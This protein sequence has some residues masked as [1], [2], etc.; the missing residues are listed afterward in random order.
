MSVSSSNDAERAGVACQISEVGYSV[1]RS[2]GQKPPIFWITPDP[3]QSKVVFGLGEEHPVY[4]L[5]GPKHRADQPPMTLLD[6][7]H[8]YAATIRRL[9]PSGPC[10]LVGYCVAATA[11]REVAG[12]LE[13]EGREVDRVVMIDPPDPAETRGGWPL[14]PLW[15]RLRFALN[16]ARFHVGRLVQ[17]GVREQV[18]YL[19][20]SLQELSRRFTYARTRRVHED[21]RRSGANLPAAL[22]DNYFASVAAFQNSAPAP[23]SVPVTLI[24]P[25]D[26]PRG[27]FEYANRRWASL[28]NGAWR[29]AEVPGDSRS[30]W[31]GDGASSLCTL[32]G[33]DGSP[34]HGQVRG[35][36]DAAALASAIGAAG[37]RSR[38]E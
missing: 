38:L 30:M 17:M 2:A 4:L 33:G 23:I 14:D 26:V 7:A 13:A 6:M 37:F 1:L 22:T 12:L 24:R 35:V 15:Y 8:C 18:G 34:P 28:C 21:A 16:R 25:T 10:V 27:A 19:R 36:A 32:I 11:A 5:R 3:S 20:S 9:R 29:V 31:G